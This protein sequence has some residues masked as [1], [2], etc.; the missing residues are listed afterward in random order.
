MFD[1]SSLDA[2]FEELRDQYEL[3]PEW[4][5]IQRAAHLGVARSDAGVPLGDIDSRV[6]SAIRSTPTPDLIGQ[7]V[8]PCPFRCLPVQR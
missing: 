2:L 5:D 8:H 7:T 3:E 6:T 1:K 4:E